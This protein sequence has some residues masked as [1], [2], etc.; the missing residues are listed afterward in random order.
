ME[1]SEKIRNMLNRPGRI[2]I[3]ATS[4]EDGSPNAAVFG[5]AHMKDPNSLLVCTGN[6]RTFQNLRKNPK[7]CLLVVT[8]AEGHPMEWEGY[9]LY[10]QATKTETEGNLLEEFKKQAAEAVGAEIAD[11]LQAVIIFKVTDIRPLIDLAPGL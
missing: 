5:S 2:G 11:L 7:A 6:N 1:V 8:K 9:R 3:L 4:N 10:L